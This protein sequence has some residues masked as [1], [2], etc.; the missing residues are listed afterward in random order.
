MEQPTE[1]MVGGFGPTPRLIEIEVP[2]DSAIFFYKA[3]IKA[4]LEAME[5]GKKLF[6][7]AGDEGSASRVGNAINA[8]TAF[9]DT[10]REVE[11]G[12][13]KEFQEFQKQAMQ[14]Q[15][16]VDVGFAPR[17]ELG[18]DDDQDNNLRRGR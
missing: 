18:Q 13:I 17:I 7:L 16:C 6:L 10:V 3:G 9:L 2:N 4:G 1:E 8:L 15:Q 12:I 11:V 14:P 5:Q